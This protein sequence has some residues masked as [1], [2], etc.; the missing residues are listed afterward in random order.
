[1]NFTKAHTEYP[2]CGPTVEAIDGDFGLSEPSP[3]VGRDIPK[4]AWVLCL[5]KLAL[6]LGFISHYL[7]ELGEIT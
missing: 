5:D 2:W 7:C 4:N 1:M 3:E 6:K